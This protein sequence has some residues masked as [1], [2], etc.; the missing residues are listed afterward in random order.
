[1]I[2]ESGN[3]AEHLTCF[4]GVTDTLTGL[5]CQR[6]PVETLQARVVKVVMNVFGHLVKDVLRATAILLEVVGA[7]GV[8]SGQ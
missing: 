3:R 7:K 8:T 5:L 6:R 4:V 1:M 2:E